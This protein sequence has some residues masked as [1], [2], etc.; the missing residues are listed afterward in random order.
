MCCEHSLL[1]IPLLYPHIIDPPPK[2]YFG[3]HF[4]TPYVVDQLS[5]QWEQVIVL[6][7]LVI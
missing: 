1:F 7:H 2:I 5:D 4:L 3:E 6:Y